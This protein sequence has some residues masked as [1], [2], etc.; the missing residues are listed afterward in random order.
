MTTSHP[1]VL[2]LWAERFDEAAA[3]IYITELRKVGLHTKLVGLADR[4][5]VGAHG[6]ALVADWTL[7]EAL[8]QAQSVTCV[9][10]PAQAPGME[11]LNNDPRVRRFFDR[12]AARQ[13]TLVIGPPEAQP[14]A[15]QSG[16]PFVDCCSRR[17]M[18]DSVRQLARRLLASNQAAAA[19]RQRQPLAELPAAQV[20]GYSVIIP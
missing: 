1:E 14:L 13:T 9:I 3:T 12:L 18:I 17:E 15:Q 8:A 20:P 11:R 16:L 2:V 7:E 6:L 19:A 5:A 10:I 4:A